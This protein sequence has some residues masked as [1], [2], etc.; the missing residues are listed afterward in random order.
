MNAPLARFFEGTL[1]LDELR[2]AA[3][4]RVQKD[5][6]TKTIAYLG[7]PQET[8]RLSPSHLIRLCDFAIEGKLSQEELSNI[9]FWIQAADEVEWDEREE[10]ITTTIFDWA[11]PEINFPSYSCYSEKISRAPRDGRSVSRHRMKKEPN[12]S[13]QPTPPSQGG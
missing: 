6:A 1:S 2:E 9:A 11:C 5:G 7:H 13:P 12:Q 10:V 3:K 8:L 4:M